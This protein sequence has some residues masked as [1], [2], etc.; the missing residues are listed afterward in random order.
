MAVGVTW[1]PEKVIGGLRDYSKGAKVLN[2]WRKMLKKFKKSDREHKLL[3]DSGN[4]TMCHKC[5]SAYERYYNLEADVEKTLLRTFDDDGGGGDEKEDEGEVEGG[6]TGACE[7]AGDSPPPD[8][9][10]AT[11]KKVRHPASNSSPATPSR[12]R[13]VKHCRFSTSSPG[14]SVGT[15]YSK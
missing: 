12:Y 9:F 10:S 14:V 4:L 3:K 6:V 13:T 1:R 5:F 8:V 7:G 2:V 11:S 15:N